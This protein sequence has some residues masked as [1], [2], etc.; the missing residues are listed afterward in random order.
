VSDRQAI[1]AVVFRLAVAAL[2]VAGLVLLLLPGIA[3]GLGLEAELAPW[4]LSR[5]DDVGGDDER[6]LSSAG[7]RVAPEQLKA[8]RRQWASMS[9][10]ER[11]QR[12][13]Q[14]DRLAELDDE[15]RQTLVENYRQWRD[16]SEQ[17]RQRLIR[18]AAALAEFEASLSRQDLAV[19]DSLAG[20]D[21]A[22]QL[23]RLWQA[24][25]QSN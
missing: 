25:Q 15:Q 24:R 3:R 11:Q 12:L 14:L 19:L 21:R 10:A 4:A 9:D 6:L 22:R 17:D 23:V 2:G 5:R 8:N 16:L 13:A 20:K 7:W 1:L 18:Q